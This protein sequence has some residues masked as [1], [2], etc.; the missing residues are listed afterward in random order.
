MPEK[1]Q[2]IVA[3][4]VYVLESSRYAKSRQDIHDALVDL[5]GNPGIET[6]ARDTVA[7]AL[8]RFK[9][10]PTLDFA[11][12]WLAPRP[13]RKS[14]SLKLPPL[15]FEPSPKQQQRSCQSRTFS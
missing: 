3:E 11:D 8:K 13:Q 12:C 9:E 6:V 7:N 4:V 1:G 5:L 14:L 10:K 15:T 2:A